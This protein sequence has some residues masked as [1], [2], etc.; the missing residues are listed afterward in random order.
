M[1]VPE[2]TDIRMERADTV[3]LERLRLRLDQDQVAAKAELTQP[4]VSK[5]E[6]GRGSDEVYEAIEAALSELAKERS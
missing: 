5:A 4:T 2:K 1:P 3:R 6:N